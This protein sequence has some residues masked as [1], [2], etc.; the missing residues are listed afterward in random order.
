MRILFAGDEHPYSAYA[1][2]KV[3]ELARHTWSD[4]TF[5]SVC[6]PVSS[7]QDGSF[8]LP[9][10]HPLIQ[11][12]D[13]YRDEFLD[14][15]GN[16]DSP[17]SLDRQD[18]ECIPLRNGSWEEMKVCRGMK[19][20]VNIRLRTGI[21]ETEILNEAA[22]DE[23]DLIVLGCSKGSRSVWET[24]P[25]VPQKVTGGAGCSVLL[26]K[27]DKPVKRILACIDQV[28]VSQESLEMINQL[29]TIYNAQLELVGLTKDGGA[30]PEAYTRLIQVGDYYSDRGIPV[31]ARLADM[32][33]LEAMISNDTREDLLAFWMGKKSLL[34]ILFPRDWVERFV[35][36]SQSSIL[37]L[38]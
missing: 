18:Y 11:A 31:N 16:T 13:R 24:L 38:R 27:E 26:T 4:I 5:L 21:A 1:L 3:I 8:P 20:N 6:P 12:L 9:G 2:K 17:Y 22:A 29:V 7:P 15:L 25:Q 10:R 32:S 28:S 35:T 23:S 37:V 30:K 19:K 14:V 34:T 33:Q 36:A